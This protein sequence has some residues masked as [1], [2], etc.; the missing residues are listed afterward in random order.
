MRVECLEKVF[1]KF[2]SKFYNLVWFSLLVLTFKEFAAIFTL[3]RSTIVKIAVKN[4]T[5][6]KTN[7][8][9]VT[10]CSDYNNKT[11]ISALE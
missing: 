2:Q 8:S 9:T 4:K 6:V 5:F 11:G 10:F 1:T 3:Q 7:N